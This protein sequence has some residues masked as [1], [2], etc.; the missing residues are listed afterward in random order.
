MII[1]DVEETPETDSLVRDLS[2]RA[3]VFLNETNR[4]LSFSRNLAVARCS[5]R[6]LVFIDDDVDISAETIAAIRLAF[7]ENVAIVG[8]RVYG[9]RGSLRLPWYV[10]E[11]QLHYL[12]VHASQ[13]PFRTWGAC[14]GL[15]VEFVRSHGLG[16]RDELGRRGESLASGDDTTF[17]RAMKEHGASEVFLD[18]VGVHHEFAPA[19]LSACY[20]FRR[21]Y[22]QG[23]SEVRRHEFCRGSYKEWQRFTCHSGSQLLTYTT[24][25]VYMMAFLLGASRECVAGLLRKSSRYGCTTLGGKAS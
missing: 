18:R 3:T 7:I 14:M 22:W 12:G 20:L 16:F 8:V 2:R 4:G 13:R 23:R 6:H 15:D 21:A 5:T 25:L 9:P 17:I 19:R 24:A 11:G 1:L 10:T